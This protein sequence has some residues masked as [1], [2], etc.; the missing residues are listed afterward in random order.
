MFNQVTALTL[1]SVG[2]KSPNN[3]RERITVWFGPSTASL[4]ENEAGSDSCWSSR[5]IENFGGTVVGHSWTWWSSDWTS[6]GVCIKN[7]ITSASW[8]IKTFALTSIFVI[9]F[10]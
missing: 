3:K 1:R 8:W 4:S 5:L 7:N 2:S 9:S 10:W 6:A